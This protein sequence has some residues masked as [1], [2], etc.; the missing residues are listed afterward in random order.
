[1]YQYYQLFGHPILNSALHIVDKMSDREHR[2]FNVMVYNFTEGADW[3]GD[4]KVF[5]PDLEYGCV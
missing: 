2:K 4:M 3:K 5:R 1:M